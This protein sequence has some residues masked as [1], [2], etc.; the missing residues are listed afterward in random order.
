MWGS[1]RACQNGIFFCAAIDDSDLISF[2]NGKSTFV[3]RPNE[4]P[5]ILD[6]TFISPHLFTSISHDVW[7]DALGSDH[8][9]VATRLG[10]QVPVSKYYSHKYSLKGM[11]LTL[12][13]SVLRNLIDSRSSDGLLSAEDPQKNYNTFVECVDEAVLTACAPSAASRN[14]NSG[15]CYSILPRNFKPF[16]P[17]PWW[18]GSC[19]DAVRDRRRAI[20]EFRKHSDYKNYIAYKK[21]R[22]ES[23][24]YSE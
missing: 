24:R 4:S 11:N 20:I 23:Q 12:F 6:L 19:D 16:V 15:T 8:Y 13:S 1:A 17:A 22:S 5:S 10:V 7:D 9:P 2:N 14:G 3:N 21:N 18:N